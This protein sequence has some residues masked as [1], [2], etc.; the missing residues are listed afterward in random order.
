M[1][2]NSLLIHLVTLQSTVISLLHQSLGHTSAAVVFPDLNQ[3]I[4]SATGARDGSIQALAEQCQRMAQ[5]APLSRSPPYL[6]TSL[7]RN[8]SPS[9]YTT[10]YQ[11]SSYKS[12]SDDNRIRETI[13]IRSP[14]TSQSPTPSFIP[15]SQTKITGNEI[16]PMEKALC[17]CGWKYNGSDGWFT[18][19][20]SN[21]TPGRSSRL[22]TAF[23]LSYCGIALMSHWSGTKH[24]YG[25]M[26]CCQGGSFDGQTLARHWEVEHTREEFER[27]FP[28]G[29][30]RRVYTEYIV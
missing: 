25:C 14:H 22:R 21:T 17:S 9:R 20:L 30:Y 4:S 29:W 10:P 1:C 6:T 5:A 27:V 16:V 8:Y 26:I 7:L 15:C 24:E 19:G 3:L 18:L 23:I 2:Q 12:D 28:K 11:K 13:E